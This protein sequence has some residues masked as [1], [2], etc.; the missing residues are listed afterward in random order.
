MRSL[1]VLLVV[2][3][4][5]KETVAPPAAAPAKKPALPPPT[6]IQAQQLIA[7]SADFSDYEFT[8]ASYSLPLSR[9]AMT[10][11]ARAYAKALASAGWIRFDGDAVALTEKA[12]SDRR[13]LV[14][15]NGFADI[16]PLAKKEMGSVTAVR[17]NADGNVAADFDWTW[18][19]NEIGKVFADRYAGKQLATATLINDGSA[20]S[21]L[22]ITKR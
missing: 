19:P 13:W 16:V 2:A 12:K 1:F 7:D 6:A 17:A 10:E 14:R 21:V 3:A 9:K 15:P 22:R 4:C 18:S 11:P 5:A 8:N 20:W